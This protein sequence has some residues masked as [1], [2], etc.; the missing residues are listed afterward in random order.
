MKFLDRVDA[1]QRLARALYHYRDAHPL[2]LALPRGGV[3]PGFEVAQALG[4]PLEVFVVRKLGLPQQPEVG[5]GAIAEDGTLWADE[6]A[7]DR[8]GE[9]ALGAVAAREWTETDRRVKRY[10]GGRPLPALRGR[11]VIVV[12]DGIATGG[13]ARVAVRAVRALGPAVLVLAVPVAPA[14]VVAE[15]RAEV[16]ALVCLLAVRE[17]Q[18]V[19]FWYDDFREVSDAEV[20]AL[21]R[22]APP[23]PPIAPAPPAAVAAPPARPR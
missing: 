18:A 22:R 19:G 15:L 9:R 17:L 1:G 3:V 21:L 20:E 11:T 2:V 8:I 6:D 23:A 10:R 12:D 5:V 7:V 14:E 4:A 13:T 16:D